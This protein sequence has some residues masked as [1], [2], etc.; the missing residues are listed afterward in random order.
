MSPNRWEMP[1]TYL[2]SG[3][4]E[5]ENTPTLHA[6]GLLGARFTVVQPT[7]GTPGVE[8]YRAKT[9]QLVRT[10][11]TMAVTPYKGAVAWWADRARYLVTT[12]SPTTAQAR[13][14]V[15]GAFQCHVDPGNYACVLK[16]G[17]G[18][19]KF[20]DAVTVANVVSGAYAIPSA[21]NAKA[22]VVAASTA[23]TQTP[24][25]RCVGVLNP[26]DTTAVV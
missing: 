4:P 5:A 16:H 10:D 6:P 14:N 1:P 20:I 12:T 18:T 26:V 11:S 13:N 19:V 8:D 3:D 24:L 7:R 17:P 2:Q 23:P 15:A 21:T 22:D 9:Y 25:G